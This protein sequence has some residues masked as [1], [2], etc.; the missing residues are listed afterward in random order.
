VGQ[1]LSG[2]VLPVGTSLSQEMFCN[3]SSGNL[4]GRSPYQAGWSIPH[5]AFSYSHP[6]CIIG[7][8]ETLAI[9]PQAEISVRLRASKNRGGRNGSVEKVFFI[10]DVEVSAFEN[11][12]AGRSP[13]RTVRANIPGC[14]RQDSSVARCSP[15]LD[16][17]GGCTP[18]RGNATHIRGHNFNMQKECLQGDART[19]L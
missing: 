1:L 6:C 17:L 5:P 7:N 2:P 19:I 10:L 3:N 12:S 14:S 9:F 11:G 15:A 18:G 16:S 8:R 4:D 13:G